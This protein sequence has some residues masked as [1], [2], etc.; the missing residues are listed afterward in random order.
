MWEILA[1]QLD[2]YSHNGDTAE[3]MTAMFIGSLKLV[4]SE[5][6]K[7]LHGQDVDRYLAV[8]YLHRLYG[9]SHEQK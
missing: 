3:N 5:F 6:Q 4:E 2:R 8:N 9:K 7:R 1:Y